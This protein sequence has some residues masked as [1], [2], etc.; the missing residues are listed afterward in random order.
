MKEY[1]YFEIGHSDSKSQTFI[2][3]M[4]KDPARNYVWVDIAGLNDAGG[5]FMCLTNGFITKHLFQIVR[6][7][8]FIMPIT[9]Q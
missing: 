6:C 3:Q 7:V 8:K 9:V 5:K 2:P 4:I 1:E